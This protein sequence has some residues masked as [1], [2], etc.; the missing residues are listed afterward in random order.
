LKKKIKNL[1]G[2]NKMKKKNLQDVLEEIKQY[3]SY[4]IQLMFGADIGADDSDIKLMNREIRIWWVP[5]GTTGEAKALLKFKHLSDLLSKNIGEMAFLKIPN[6]QR[7]FYADDG[8][9]IWGTERTMKDIPDNLKLKNWMNCLD[10]R[11]GSHG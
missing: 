2:L 1:Y 9:Y 7:K 10:M 4:A 8:L 5:V 6:P 11:I 3:G